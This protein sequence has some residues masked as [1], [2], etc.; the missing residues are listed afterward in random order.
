MGDSVTFRLPASPGAVAEAR[1]AA[2]KAASER[3]LA[4]SVVETLRL[5]VSEVVT[6]SVRHAPASEVVELA[7]TFDGEL[8]VEVTDHGDGFDPQPRSGRSDEPGGWGLYLVERLSKR[9][10]VKRN[11]ST[12]VWFALP[13]A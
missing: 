13:R 10:G 7:L 2:V 12:R 3:Q 8:R 5:L 1:A 4:D 11:G 9:W 6:N